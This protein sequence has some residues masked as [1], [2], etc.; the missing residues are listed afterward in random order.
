MPAKPRMVGAMLPSRKIYVTGAYRFLGVKEGSLLE[1]VLHVLG[2]NRNERSHFSLG[3]VQLRKGVPKTFSLGAY[4]RAE[5]GG[6]VLGR[7]QKPSPHQIGSL[8]SAVSSPSGARV[9]PKN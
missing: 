1:V 4:Q 7:G 2:A 6:W 9:P 8:G 5:S 3:R